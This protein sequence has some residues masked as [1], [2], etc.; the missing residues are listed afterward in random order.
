MADGLFGLCG[1]ERADELFTCPPPPPPPPTP[2]SPSPISLT[3]SV[4]VKQHVS[5]HGHTTTRHDVRTISCYGKHTDLNDVTIK[6]LTF[7]VNLKFTLGCSRLITC[8]IIIWL[9]TVLVSVLAVLLSGYRLFSSDYL[10]CYY[11][12]TDCSRLITCCIIIWLQTVLVW[13]I[14][15]LSF[16]YRLFSSDYLLYYHLVTDCSRLST[17]CIIIWFQTVLVWLLAVLLSGYRLFSSDYLLYYYLVTDS[18][19]NGTSL[20]PTLHDH[21]AARWRHHGHKL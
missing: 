12:V 15:V 7:N 13:L 9:Q 1:S 18:G 8:C 21:A 3:A 20:I 6:R 4:D 11:L 14:A 19:E 2:P 5:D 16:G 10:L 17:C